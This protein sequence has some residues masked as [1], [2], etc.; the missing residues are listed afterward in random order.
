MHN[1][2]TSNTDFCLTEIIPLVFILTHSKGLESI[3]RLQAY[4]LVVWIPSTLGTHVKV[5]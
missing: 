5:E 3:R 4:S 1:P 2:Y